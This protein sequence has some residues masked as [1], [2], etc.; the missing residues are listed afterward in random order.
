MDCVL[1]AYDHYSV[2]KKPF[3]LW[4]PTDPRDVSVQFA[5]GIV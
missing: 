4:Y 2:F 1:F 3:N 5:Y